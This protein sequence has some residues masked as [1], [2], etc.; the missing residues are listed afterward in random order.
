MRRRLVVACVA[1]LLLAS[2]AD[3]ARA[4]QRQLSTALAVGAIHVYQRSVSPALS[5]VGFGCRFTPSCSHYAEAV[6]Q[7]HGIVRGSWMTLTRLAR[8][9][10]WTPAG[11][12]DPPPGNDG[13]R[14]R[15][16]G[17]RKTPNAS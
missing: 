10:P 7:K 15:G 8:C 12:L 16:S 4:P 2:I 6:L 1:L 13:A 17:A 9:G 11:T 14:G 3:A 5:K